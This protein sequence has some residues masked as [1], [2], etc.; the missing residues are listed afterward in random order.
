MTPRVGGGGELARSAEKSLREEC[1]MLWEKKP[2]STPTGDTEVPQGLSVTSADLEG[3]PAP[4]E[5][6][7][8]EE[9][10]SDNPQRTITPTSGSRMQ[11]VLGQGVLVKGDLSG[12]ED[13]LIEGECEG[14]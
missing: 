6:P 8:L 5:I 14:T 12:K 13:L 1:T 11:T 10:R 4:L 2:R 9:P 3:T 7:R